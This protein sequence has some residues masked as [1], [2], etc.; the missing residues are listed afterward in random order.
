MAAGTAAVADAA[1]GRR[2]ESEHDAAE[3]TAG[4]GC[5][6]CMKLTGYSVDWFGKWSCYHRCSLDWKP[7]PRDSGRRLAG[8]LRSTLPRRSTRTP[9]SKHRSHFG[10]QRTEA[11]SSSM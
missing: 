7:C 10:S 11:C 8:R 6:S 5:R 4:A 1:A 2:I 3:Q 9:S